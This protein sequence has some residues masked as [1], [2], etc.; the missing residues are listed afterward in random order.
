V[1]IFIYSA[2]MSQLAS[3]LRGSQANLTSIC[4]KMNLAPVETFRPSELELSYPVRA[5]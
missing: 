4:Q 1:G 3:T 2:A 5:A